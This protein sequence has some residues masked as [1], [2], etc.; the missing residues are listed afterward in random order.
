MI[1]IFLTGDN[2]IGLKYASHEQAAV[3]AQK[4][5]DAFGPMVQR[6]NDEDC[7]L[8]VIAGDLFWK[9]FREEIGRYDNIML[10]T[11]PE[12]KTISLDDREAV[13]YPAICTERHSRPGENNLGWI[14]KEAIF[15]DRVCRIGLA[16]GAIEGVSIDQEGAYFQMS[17]EELERIPV[18]VWLIGHTHVPYPRDLTEEYREAGKIFNAGSHVQN[19]VSTNTEGLCFVIEIADDKKVR[20]KKIVSG[21]LRFHRIPVRVT[22]GNMKDELSRAV[23][24]FGKDSVV[25][26]ILSG[27]VTDEEYGRRKEILDGLLAGFIEGSWTDYGLSRLITEDLIDAEYPETGIASGLLKSLLNNPREAQLAYDLLKEME[28]TGK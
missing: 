13:L 8:F 25:E 15:P 9:D 1:R 20:A 7:D 17:P 2:H 28:G 22:A 4:R 19:D 5:I 14:K 27:A 16:H 11:D 21:N 6:A 23:E 12:P 18:D 10:L 24:G 26:L 3:L